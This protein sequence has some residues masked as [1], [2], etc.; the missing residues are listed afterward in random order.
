MS[1]PPAS[2]NDLATII[3]DLLFVGHDMGTLPIS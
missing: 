3:N 2:F 1:S